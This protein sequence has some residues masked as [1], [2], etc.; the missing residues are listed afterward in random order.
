MGRNICWAPS[1]PSF[2]CSMQGWATGG[3]SSWRLCSLASPASSSAA[4]S[5]MALQ[6]RSSLRLLLTFGLGLIIEG[7]FR[8][9]FGSSGLPYSSLQELQGGQDLGFMFLPNYR[10][11]V[12]VFSLVVCLTTWFC[13]RTHEAWRLSAC[14]N[15]EP[16]ACARVRHQCAAHDYPHLW[17]RGCTGGCRRGHGSAGLYTSA[18]KWA[19][20]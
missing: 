20:I 9:F 15:R 8:N 17:F 18:R 3:R 19:P 14:S 11:W 12:V 4:I 13:H 1:Q 16:H 5:A 10:A 6:A 2:C 7:T